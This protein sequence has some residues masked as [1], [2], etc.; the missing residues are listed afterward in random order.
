[1]ALVKSLPLPKVRRREGS[2]RRVTP[3]QAQGNAERSE[4]RVSP[5]L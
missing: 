1:M 5:E 4:E 2:F 3:E